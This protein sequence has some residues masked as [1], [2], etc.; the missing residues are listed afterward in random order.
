MGGPESNKVNDEILGKLLRQFWE[1]VRQLRKGSLSAKEVF[2]KFKELLSG[3]RNVSVNG[4]KWEEMKKA[5]GCDNEYIASDFDPEKHLPPLSDDQQD[6]IETVLRK[7]GKTTTNREW[8][9][10]LDENESG[11]NKFAHPLVVLALGEA[12]PD[13]QRENPLFTIWKDAD[14]QLWFLCL[15]VYDGRRCLNVD[16]IDLG[17][18]WG[19]RCRAVAVAK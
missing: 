19:G 2:R 7:Q 6:E 14:G 8:L 5:C 3:S 13:E 18:S 11:N 17:D 1:I 9:K 4:R 16:R 12:D 10:I 15:D